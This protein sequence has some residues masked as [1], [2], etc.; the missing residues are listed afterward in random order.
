MHWVS[1]NWPYLI[2]AVACLCAAIW[3]TNH[4]L[5]DGEREEEE[6]EEIEQPTS[7]PVYVTVDAWHGFDEAHRHH[8]PKWVENDSWSEE[9]I[10]R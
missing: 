3:L 4:I 1:Q 9:F 5:A 10:P 6:L 7:T 2:V 8:P